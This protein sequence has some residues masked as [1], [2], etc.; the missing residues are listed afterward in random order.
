MKRRISPLFQ[1]T[2]LLTILLFGVIAVSISVLSAWSLH[3]NMTEEYISKGEA[4]AQSIATSSVEVLLN[5]DA[6]TAQ[7]MV[8]Q[9]LEIHGTAYVLVSDASGRP[10][11][12]TFV[13]R[14][15][16][17]VERLRPSPKGFTVTD[18]KTAEGSYIDVSK[19]ILAGVAGTVHVGMD[20]GLIHEY[21]LDAVAR[22]QALL[23]AI[24]AVAIV[25]LYLGVRRVS[26]PLSALTDYAERLSRHDFDAPMPVRSRHEIGQLATTLQNMADEIKGL[27]GDMQSRVDAS[28]S[29]LRGNLLFTQAIIDNLADGLLV[30][31]INGRI[32]RFNPMLLRMFGFAED[33]DLGGKDVSLMFPLDLSALA[34]E[35][36]TCGDEVL[37]AEV[38]LAEGNTGKA[39]ARPIQEEES[40]GAQ[41]ACLGAV[42]V[43]RDVTREKEIDRM[44]T[45][46]ITTVSHELR[47]PLTSVLGFAK[48]IQRRLTDVIFPSL[49]ERPEKK[50]A[51]AVDQVADNISIIVSEGERLTELIN[52]VLDISKMEAGKIEWRMRETNMGELVR[53]SMA[54]VEY[55]LRDKN[56]DAETDIEPGLPRVRVDRDRLV[57][58]VINLLSNAIKFTEH[59]RVA[60]SVRSRQDRLVVSVEDTGAGIPAKD[61]ELVFDRFRQSGDT[62]T[63]KPKGTGLGLPI[64]RYI[65]ESHGGTIWVESHPGEGSAFHF[66][67]PVLARAEDETGRAAAPIRR[68]ALNRPQRD[69]RRP[70][71]LLVVDDDQAVRTYLAQLLR[72]EGFA[73]DEAA[74]GLQALDRAVTNPPDLITMDLMMPGMDG[75]TVITS[76]R[77]NAATR[78]I[79]VLVITALQDEPVIGADARLLK[80]IHEDQ[81][82]ETI[83]ALLHND[84]LAP[85]PCMVIAREEH[86]SVKERLPMLC[87]GQ[88]VT[89]P[90]EEIEEKINGGFEGTIFIPASIGGTIDLG[91]LAKASSVQLV[92]LPE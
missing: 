47:T 54:S 46:F 69:D 29:E 31:D 22:Q 19:P 33:A 8:D 51:R 20:R 35:A 13:P 25:A 27:V 57:Q 28:T 3:R 49:G 85:R 66:S 73:V 15:P 81:L 79:P 78:R 87:P 62:L 37:T 65:V 59:G 68:A 76:L 84:R 42:V 38:A 89:C 55:L 70:W 72:S 16:P 45:D 17:S 67:I 32:S 12:H 24:M 58:V 86:A 48:I 6:S 1:R 60:V 74:N 64:C 82:L 10:I 36:A 92:I 26:L 63:E 41:A 44:K 34:E 90:P 88:V 4:I 9:Y 53:Q 83:N 7:A 43:I 52:D 75:G 56:L 71:R 2:L 91:K 30:T 40:E 77:Q 80:P 14:V 5:R 61:Q 11:A 23:L 18:I 50:I 21:I 39:L